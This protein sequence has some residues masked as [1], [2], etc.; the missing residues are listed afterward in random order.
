MHLNPKNSFVIFFS[1]DPIRLF[2]HLSVFYV[3]HIVRDDQQI[4][5]TAASMA[6]TTNGNKAGLLLTTGNQQTIG[7]TAEPILTSSSTVAEN[8]EI[9]HTKTVTT[10]Q[11]PNVTSVIPGSGNNNITSTEIGY[12]YILNTEI[13]PNVT[14]VEPTTA[15]TPS[16]PIQST[17]P[18]AGKRVNTENP[19]NRVIPRKSTSIR[20]PART[21][22]S[23]VTV[24]SQVTLLSMSSGGFTTAQ[25]GFMSTKTT[26]TAS[27]KTGLQIG[28]SDNLL[29]IL[30]QIIC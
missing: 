12:T 4:V 25:P 1:R 5:T 16:T 21:A 2:Q 17:T 6:S 26:V 7:T 23:T 28:K 18:S 29:F 19:G 11:G 13:M 24:T 27:D 30:S 22:E 8:T 20:T 10:T 15:A 9:Y 3:L 14:T